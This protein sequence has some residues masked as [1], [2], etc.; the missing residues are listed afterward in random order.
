M[1]RIP[2][3]AR[4]GLS[5]EQP[6]SWGDHSVLFRQGV[7]DGVSIHLWQALQF[8]WEFTLMGTGLSDA[9]AA[10]VLAE[11]FAS[12]DDS[13]EHLQDCAGLS[14]RR[15]L[16]DAYDRTGFANTAFIASMMPHQIGGFGP[17]DRRL[18]CLIAHRP[19]SYQVAYAE[20]D[21]SGEPTRYVWR[22]A[23]GDANFIAATAQPDIRNIERN[24]TGRRSSGVPFV[25]ALHQP[26]QVRIF[27]LF[28]GPP[29]PDAF[30][31]HVQLIE[32]GELPHISGARIDEDGDTVIDASQLF[33]D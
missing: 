19:D 21:R 29:S 23:F 32:S 20:V 24:L 31:E 22:T 5:A 2:V 26:D 7:I 8:D 17:D 25:L 27:G 28:N 13:A 15:Q 33:E 4:A 30:L 1:D 3:A 16:R 18:D 12:M 6:L 9:A 10:T 11:A 14:G